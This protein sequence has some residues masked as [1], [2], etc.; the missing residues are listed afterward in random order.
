MLNMRIHADGRCIKVAAPAPVVRNA[1]FIGF[2]SALTDGF[3]LVGVI[4]FEPPAST[5][6][7]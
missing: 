6:R 3:K 2:I 7:T 5:S 1:P 4:G